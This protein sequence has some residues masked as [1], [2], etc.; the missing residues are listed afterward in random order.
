LIVAEIEKKGNKDYCGI[1]DELAE[2]WRIPLLTGG[3]E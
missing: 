2:F 3:E 1:L